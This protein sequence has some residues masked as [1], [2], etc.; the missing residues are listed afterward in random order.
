MTNGELIDELSKYPREAGTIVLC[1]GGWVQA[2]IEE[3]EFRPD[4]RGVNCVVL[5]A[6]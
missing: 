4:R 5:V 6:C 3:I 2:D 1:E